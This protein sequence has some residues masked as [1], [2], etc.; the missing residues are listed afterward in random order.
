M[1]IDAAGALVR[2]EDEV[3]TRSIAVSYAGFLNNQLDHN[4]AAL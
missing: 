1:F 3:M 2:A 4:V